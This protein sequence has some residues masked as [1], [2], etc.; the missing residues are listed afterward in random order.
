MKKILISFFSVLGIALLA[1][2]D[3]NGTGPWRHLLN[4]RWFAV[5][6]EDHLKTFFEEWS[7]WT[8]MLCNAIAVAVETFYPS[9]PKPVL[10]NYLT[11]LYRSLFEG[12][13]SQVRITVFRIRKGYQLWF[14]FFFKNLFCF[15]KHVKKGTLRYQFLSFPWLP[16][17]KYIAIYARFGNPHQ[18]GTMT[19]FKFPEGN[20]DVNGIASYVL[21]TQQ[22]FSV[23]L[24][25]INSFKVEQFDSINDIPFQKKQ[26]VLEY[27]KKSR[28]KSFDQ[29]KSIHSKAVHIWATPIVGDDNVAWGVL[30]VDDVKNKNPFDDTH[31]DQSLALASEIIFTI[32]RT[33]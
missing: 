22:K 23:S 19:I 17:K 33:V 5:L 26:A 21:M 18:K 31:V 7:L 15:F 12:D 9:S 4:Q 2:S 16:W 27:I 30:V 32:L 24:P 10:R 1:L 14:S 8:G 20:E 13:A 6:Y 25:N 28:L 3:T 11:Q 29:L